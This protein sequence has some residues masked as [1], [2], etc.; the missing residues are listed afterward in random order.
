MPKRNP[1]TACFITALM[2]TTPALF[3]V[4][5]ASE[6]TGTVRYIKI[7]ASD[8]LHF[9]EINGT[10]SARPACAATYGYYIIRQEQ[11]DVGKAHLAALMSAYF[12]RRPIYIRGSGNCTRWGD[13]EDIEEVGLI[14]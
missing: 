5:Q 7:R 14:E 13:G 3:G 8:G 4:A 9:V 11:S 2:M 1:G 12:A 10:P 6:I